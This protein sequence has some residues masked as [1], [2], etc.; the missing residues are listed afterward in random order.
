MR[1]WL[2][3]TSV[4]ISIMLKHSW[5]QYYAQTHYIHLHPSVLQRSLISRFLCLSFFFW[6][7]RLVNIIRK[8][9]LNDTAFI[10][11]CV[12]IIYSTHAKETSAFGIAIL[13]TQQPFSATLFCRRPPN[14]PSLAFSPPTVFKYPHM[15]F[16][17]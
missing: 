8:A 3:P 10:N 11:C 13:L 7:L 15:L 2:L 14:H 5:Y 4:G 6:K 17:K 12:V 9:K 16:L 1:D